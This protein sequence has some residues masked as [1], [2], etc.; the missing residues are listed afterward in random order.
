MPTTRPT[1]S[2]GTRERSA[3]RQAGRAD[4]RRRG[5]HGKVAAGAAGVAVAPGQRDRDR[6]GALRSDAPQRA[7]LRLAVRALPCRRGR[8][9]GGHASGA[10]PRPVD[11]SGPVGGQAQADRPGDHAARPPRR[12]HA[13]RRER[14][15]ST[16]RG[17]RVRAGQQL[18]ATRRR[19]T[20]PDAGQG[21]R[22]RPK[23]AE[24]L[25]SGLATRGYVVAVEEADHGFPATYAEQ[26]RVASGVEVVLLQQWLRD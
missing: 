12:R 20:A 11:V 24:Y 3:N 5:T 9:L 17:V 16:G 19:I 1:T 8:A 10:Q 15:A 21:R 22:G 2:P 18:L 23:V 25:R 26:A 7:R 4:R 14:R 6:V 13:T